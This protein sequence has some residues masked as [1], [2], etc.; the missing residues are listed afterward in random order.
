MSGFHRQLVGYLQR[1]DDYGCQPTGHRPLGTP[2]GSTRIWGICL[3]CPDNDLRD[4]NHLIAIDR[5]LNRQK[6]AR[7]SAEWLDPNPNYLVAYAQAW[8]DVKRKWGLTADAEEIAALRQLLSCL[9]KR[10]K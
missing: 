1:L 8:V 7:D 6:G 2:E 9:D 4:P 10:Q 5:S 3:G